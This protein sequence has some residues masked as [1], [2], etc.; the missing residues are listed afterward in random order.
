M[1][2]RV[3]IHSTIK[4]VLI[5]S[6]QNK[7]GY[8]YIV[9]ASIIPLVMNACATYHSKPLN[10]KVVSEELEVPDIKELNIKAAATGNPLLKPVTIDFN[11]GI[12]P[13]EAAILSV[14]GN[15]ELRAERDKKGIARAQL[16]QAGIL[17]NPQL[18]ITLDSPVGGTTEGT[19]NALG[20]NFGW[21]ITSLIT[22]NAF[23]QAARA[24][25]ESVDL[26][27]A[28]Q[29][30]Q[31]AEA[32]KQQVYHLYFLKKQ[33]EVSA[34]EQKNLV[35][36]VESIRKAVDTGDMTIIDL[37]AAES[38]LKAVELSHLTI[39]QQISDEQIKL[40]KSLG[41][42]PGKVI[43]LDPST[44]PLLKIEIPAY[45]EIISGLEQ[46]RLD[47][48][49]LKSGYES[50]E[51]TLRGAVL[52]QF[53]KLN[54]GF[55]QMRDTGNVITSGFGITIDLPIFDHNQGKIAIESAT[56]QQLYDEYIDRVYSTR[57]T[58]ATILT[59]ISS[60]KQQ[61]K[62]TEE[63]VKTLNT[64]VESYYE[65]FLVGNADVISYYNAKN[66]LISRQIDVYK[67]KQSLA[68]LWIALELESGKYLQNHNLDVKNS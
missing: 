30:W 33:L 63:S 29:E 55:T 22:H 61:I 59:D 10:N 37:S 47:L 16:L 4:F 42:P 7:S 46:H 27:I 8:L 35:K 54:I 57:S 53:P 24:Q 49:A 56:R 2:Y 48:L 17:P 58:I 40:N 39:Q 64:L 21:D 32:A 19:V 43:E 20:L 26:D 62:T 11:N 60:L 45:E 23:K 9:M 25:Y 65:A 3:K 52:G 18:G 36:N 14:I 34:Q 50:Q 68:D 5:N 15:Y 31:L 44:E 67:L 38:A 1:K 41:F 66:D 6:I 13:D 51:A 28:W 12:S